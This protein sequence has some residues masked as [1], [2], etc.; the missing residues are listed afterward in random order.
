MIA[1]NNESFYK[2]VVINLETN[3]W[4]WNGSHYKQKPGFLAYGTF[5]IEGK[6]HLAHRYSYSL[7]KGE[8]P[9]GLCV[10][11]QCDN[12][13]CVNPDH[14]FLGTHMDNTIDKMSKGRQPKGDNH[15]R[16]KLTETQVEEIKLSN[17]TQLELANIYNVSQQHIS[18]LK[19]NQRRNK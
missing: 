15:G 13:K 9:E 2:K 14:L 10:L 12:P 4:D 16:S 17:L 7:L 5:C 11:H 6:K 18:R 1:N 8:I 19:K 3:C